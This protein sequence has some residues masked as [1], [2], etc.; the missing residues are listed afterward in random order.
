M[1][2]LLIDLSSSGQFVE[3]NSPLNPPK[4]GTLR[5]ATNGFSKKLD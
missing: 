4:R 1:E 5:D 2:M 3:G